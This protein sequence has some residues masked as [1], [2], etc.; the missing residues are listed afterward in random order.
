MIGTDL[1]NWLASDFIAHGWSVKHLHRQIVLS[2]TYRESAN[3]DPKLLAADPD[4]RLLGRFNR[5]RAEFE[6]MRDTLMAVAGTLNLKPG[7][8]PDD[9]T[10]EPFSTRRT[11]YAFIDRQN[12]PGIF[13]T[14]DLPN[15]DVSSPQRFAT[16]VP[17]QALFM[18]NSPFVQEQARAL[19]ARTETAAASSDRDRVIA[20]YRLL[21]Q[22]SPDRAELDMALK[23]LGEP[24]GAG[25]QSLPKTY[26]WQLGYGEFDAERGRIRGFM[27]MPVKK[28]G[29]FSPTKDLPAPEF[30][31]LNL[32]AQGGHPGP[33]TGLAAIRRWISPVD[34]TI[35]VRGKLKHPAA[36]GDGVRGRIV[37]NLQGLLAEATVH[38]GEGELKLDGV[39]VRAGETFDFAADCVTNDGWDSFDWA[40]EIVVTAGKSAPPVKLEWSARG[41]FGRPMPTT[42][43]MSRLEQLAQV[44][45]LSN[46]LAFIE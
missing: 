19:S 14:F 27:E 4:G 26:G 44:L 36:Q 32:T 13:R 31:Y 28:D 43:S 25:T 35:N 20:L 23:F 17:Q 2:A 34:G 1:L 21:Y 37:S 33:R 3:A 30:A 8:L 39:R 46:E 18:M 15:P 16:T 12:L 10:V 38:H 29:H 11:V 7:G 41:D 9:I 45:L 42:K 6:A 24:K 22:R 40:P 5:H